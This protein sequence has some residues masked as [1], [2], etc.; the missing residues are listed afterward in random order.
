MGT[1]N[2]VFVDLKFQGRLSK[3]AELV[4]AELF[5]FTSLIEEFGL[6]VLNTPGYCLRVP[7]EDC[8]TANERIAVLLKWRGVWTPL[9]LNF[10]Q[11]QIFVLYDG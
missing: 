5:L 11:P 2:Q 9:W 8:T 7:V 3:S 1:R 4:Q 10:Q 6:T